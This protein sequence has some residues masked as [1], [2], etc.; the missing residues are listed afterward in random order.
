MFETLKAKL[1]AIVLF[2]VAFSIISIVITFITVNAQKSDGVVINLAGKQRMLLQKMTKE[3]L[4]LHLE[5]GEPEN[6]KKTMA[7]FDKTLKGLIAGDEELKL[8]PTENTEIKDKLTDVNSQWQDFQGKLAS[9]MSHPKGTPDYEEDF[10]YVVKNNMP[11]LA[12]MNSIVEAFEADSSSKI[13]RLKVILLVSLMLSILLGSLAIYRLRKDVLYPLERVG[14]A[15]ARIAAGDI[16]FQLKVKRHDEI[17]TLRTNFN[18]MIQNIKKVNNEL[19][20]EKAGVEQKIELAII[21]SEKQRLYLQESTNVML[22]KMESFSRGD[23]TVELEVKSSDE[24]G[25]LFNGFNNSIQNIHDILLK[26]MDMIESTSGASAQISS[27]AEEMAAG[28]HE[29]EA[30]AQEIAASVEQM[31]RVIYE[32]N[33]ASTLVMQKAKLAGDSALEGERIV[34]E[35]VKGMN[36]IA[37][38]VRSAADTV[39]ELGKNSVKIEEIVQVINDIAEQTNLLALN[40]AIEAARAGEQG[41]GFAVV[42]DEV[43]KLADRTT[44][45]TGEI[46]GMIKQIQRDT[47]AAVASMQQGTQNVESG[48]ILAEKAGVS[49][50]EITKSAS[51]VLEEV[52]KVT[53]ASAEQTKAA[54]EIERSIHGITTVTRETSIG[55]QELAKASENLNQLTE[56]LLRLAGAFRYKTNNQ[57]G[58]QSLS[59]GKKST[60]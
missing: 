23:L 44:K 7:L 41:R 25:A 35:T 9:M 29:Q 22:E 30:Q 50:K 32:S 34:Q 52:S 18:T 24:I 53:K 60:W 13:S 27:S 36:H 21:E 15:A 31:T 57:Y 58:K 54:E 17:G 16:D 20:N 56:D 2:L 6:L 33:T 8:P 48:R 51:E 3:M 55:I 10:T 5:K 39:G 49:L 19:R 47:S 28:A 43:R 38:V 46:G 12:K 42:A 1:S 4:L 45:A 59:A 40:A 14:D 26:V 37:T 11:L